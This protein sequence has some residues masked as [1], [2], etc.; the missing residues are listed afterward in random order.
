MSSENN[1]PNTIS[2]TPTSRPPLRA[3]FSGLFNGTSAQTS[4]SK[5]EDQDLD[6]SEYASNDDDLYV[7]DGED[8]AAAADINGVK[9]VT[10]S[11]SS[12]Q[13]ATLRL[14]PSISDLT[15]TTHIKLSSRPDSL[16]PSDLSHVNP[17]PPVAPTQNT[18][19]LDIVQ[20]VKDAIT[21]GKTGR[22]EGEGGIQISH[23]PTNK[24]SRRLP[25]SHF[26]RFIRIILL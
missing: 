19:F 7:S 2:Q 22:R 21:Q 8:D 14:V 24:L 10:Q 16:I 25:N 3:A 11:L 9:G 15:D 17:V 13:I 18:D 5:L 12:Q 4:Y 20:S 23:S 6:I 1:L 26:A